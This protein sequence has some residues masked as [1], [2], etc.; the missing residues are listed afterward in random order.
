MAVD[1]AA[2]RARASREADTRA[3]LVRTHLSNER[4]FLSWLRTALTLITLGLAAGRFLAVQGSAGVGVA[5][6]LALVLILGGIAL[7]GAGWLRYTHN[8]HAIDTD[9]FRPSVRMVAA[10]TGLIVVLG[11]LAGGFVLVLGA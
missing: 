5:Q 1:G 10:A 9:T 3:E 8:Q 6:V 7:V 2:P 11:L 4:T